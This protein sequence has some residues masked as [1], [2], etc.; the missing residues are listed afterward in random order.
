VDEAVLVELDLGGEVCRLKPNSSA[1]V[2]VI[3]LFRQLGLKRRHVHP[4][5]PIGA[6]R[7]RLEEPITQHRQRI[8]QRRP[9]QIEEIGIT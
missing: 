7:T 4:P 2:R 5:H 3:S 8:E 6:F 9:G 1:T